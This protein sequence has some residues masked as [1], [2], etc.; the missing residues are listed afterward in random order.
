MVVRPDLRLLAISY[1]NDE[2]HVYDL[3]ETGPAAELAVIPGGSG[4]FSPDGTRLAVSELA[5]T[6][7]S[8]T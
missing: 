7:Y 8:T 2:L 6:A 4:S 5:N 3:P 1:D